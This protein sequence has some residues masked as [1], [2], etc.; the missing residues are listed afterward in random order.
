MSPCPY[1]AV[2]RTS[3]S[4]EPLSWCPLPCRGKKK[5]EKIVDGTILTTRTEK[6]FGAR[7]DKAANWLHDEKQRLSPE[8]IARTYLYL[9]RQ[10]PDA[11][12]LEL[13]LRCVRRSDLSA[14]LMSF[15]NFG[16]VCPPLVNRG[17]SEGLRRKNSEAVFCVRGMRFCQSVLCVALVCRIHP[18]PI[19]RGSFS[20]GTW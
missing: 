11:W 7:A 15:T 13:D 8:S 2:S 14:A 12:T 5:H 3:H 9:H 20:G 4:K 18:W 19:S 17:F 1:S 16:F 10:T 6:N